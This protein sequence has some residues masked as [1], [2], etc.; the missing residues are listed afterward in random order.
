MKTFSFTDKDIHLNNLLLDPNNYRFFD[1]PSYKKKIYKKYHVSAVQ[2]ATL[3]LLEQ[4]KRY[5]L[6]EL[7]R[8]ILKN[9]YVPMERVVVVPYEHKKGSYL[10]IE[11]NRRIAALKSLLQE[12]KEGVRELSS[13]QIKTF[14]TIPSAMLCAS[15]DEIIHAQR[16]IMGIRHIAGPKEWGAYQQAQLI[17]ELYETEGQDFQSIADHLGVS[18]VDVSRRYRAMKALKTMEEDELYAGQSRYEYYRLFNELVSL[19]IVKDYFSWDD[20]KLKF[21]DTAKAR[22]FY[23]L[24]A[25]QAGD[26]DAKLRTFSDV[27][28]LRLILP[29]AKATA[30]LMDPEKTLNDALEIA[31]SLRLEKSRQERPIEEIIAEINHSLSKVDVLSLTKL[32]VKEIGLIEG[33]INR[34]KNLLK[35][36]QSKKE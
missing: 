3:R 22:E 6:S 27:R 25:L 4:D 9:G 2:E 31:E 8:S 5:Q 18:A 26:R 11:G 12:N 30:V 29:H 24:I 19:T 17:V 7:K 28:N 1:N 35:V 23:E 15:K 13:E 32:N 21:N 34:L 36:G 16:V 20:S 33:V 10:V 14:T